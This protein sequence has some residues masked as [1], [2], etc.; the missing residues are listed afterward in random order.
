MS[1]NHV[2]LAARHFRDRKCRKGY[3]YKCEYSLRWA[4]LSSPIAN[5]SI[6]SPTNP[7]INIEC[8]EYTPIFCFKKDQWLS[9]GGAPSKTKKGWLPSR[10]TQSF[11]R[12]PTP[13]HGPSWSARC[14]K[15]WD[16]PVA[17][18][19]CGILGSWK[20][21]TANLFV[22]VENPYLW[23][24]NNMYIYICISYYII[25]YYILY[26]ILYYIL[27]FIILYNIIYICVYVYID[28]II[29]AHTLL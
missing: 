2:P 12:H 18:W 17:A 20:P 29:Y 7:R 26:I 19:I 5:N 27:Y 4:A 13:C 8:I 16:P 6:P 9:F 24:R 3:R 28:M 10:I 15:R 21:L 22:A 1:S 25:L 23:T 14:A 11:P